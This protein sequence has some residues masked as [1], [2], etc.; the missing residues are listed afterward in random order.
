MKVVLLLI[1]F[2]VAG[3]F[4]FAQN[5]EQPDP[6]AKAESQA[7]LNICWGKE[8]KAADVTLNQV[9]QQLVAQLS[10]AEKTQLKEVELAWL[11]YRDA[12]CTFVADEYKGGSIRP[13]ILAMCL[14]DMTNNRTVEIKNQIRD[15][16]H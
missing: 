16:E 12:N 7:D 8:Y 13:M 9:Y 2:V 3:A 15:R 11:K 1:L 5:K 10:D 14:T 6:C 4:A